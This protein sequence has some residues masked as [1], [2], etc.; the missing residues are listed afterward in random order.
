[1]PGFA[2]VIPSGSTD[3]RMVKVVATGTPGTILHTV[4]AGTDDMDEVFVWAVNSDASTQKLTIELG[5]VST[6]DDL[7]EFT[8]PAEDGLYLVV[9]GIRLQN[10]AIVRAFAAT[11]NLVMCVTNVNRIFRTA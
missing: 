6:P 3:G 7:I 11:T 2:P 9:P 1:M 5:G 8:V 10:G 4:V